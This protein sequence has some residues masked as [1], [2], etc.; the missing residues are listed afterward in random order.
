MAH[1]HCLPS[2]NIKLVIEDSLD[3]TD[4]QVKRHFPRHLTHEIVF[5]QVLGLFINKMERLDVRVPQRL[6]S[7]R[8][9]DGN[10][11]FEKGVAGLPHLSVNADEDQIRTQHTCNLS[12]IDDGVGA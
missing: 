8:V 4:N 12:S 7:S 5:S 9:E 10:T 6:L 1:N 3:K 2:F 11:H